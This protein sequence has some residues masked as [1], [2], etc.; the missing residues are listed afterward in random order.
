MTTGG[1]TTAAQQLFVRLAA[2]WHHDTDHRSSPSRIADHDAYLKILTLGRA[3]VPLI[4]QDLRDHGGDWYRALRI[5]TDEN[6]VPPEHQ[7]IPGLMNE[8]W[9]N[10]GRTHGLIE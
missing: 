10:W 5:L 2:Q 6:P 9:I 3:A 7:G 4:L 8:D 1:T